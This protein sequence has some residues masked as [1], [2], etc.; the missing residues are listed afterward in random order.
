MSQ[1][2]L[3]IDLG[4]KE[5]ALD[6]RPRAQHSLYVED[7]HFDSRYSAYLRC[8]SCL[9]DVYLDVLSA[10]HSKLI[11]DLADVVSKTFVAY[12][13]NYGSQKICKLPVSCVTTSLGGSDSKI[14]IDT[15]LQR[16]EHLPAGGVVVDCDCNHASS[17]HDLLSEIAESLRNTLLGREWAAGVRILFCSVLFCSVVLFLFSL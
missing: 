9:N 3:C 5:K 14:V 16:L 6:W 15:V 17:A 12:Q 8:E 2:A 7:S 10:M 13:Q 11:D 1:S 4:S